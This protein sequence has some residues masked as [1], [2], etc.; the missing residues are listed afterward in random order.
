MTA[1][2]RIRQKILHAAT[3]EVFAT[4]DAVA[5]AWTRLSDEG[6]YDLDE[7]TQRVRGGECPTDVPA[8]GSRHYAT[9]SVAARM[10]DGTWVGWTFYHGGG[11]HGEPAQEPWMEAAY[12]LD[13]V[14]VMMP[15]KVFTR[16][17]PPPSAP[18]R[19]E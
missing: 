15:V 5:D 8:P 6:L 7:A 17:P 1:R 14:E 10:L 3:G 13:V 19:Q 11:R 9:R 12:D 18:P 2:D 4:A 16:R